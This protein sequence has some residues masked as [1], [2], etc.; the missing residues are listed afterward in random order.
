MTDREGESGLGVPIFFSLVLL[1]FVPIIA[2]VVDELV[3]R[4]NFFSRSSPEWVE[5]VVRMIY[6]PIIKMV[7]QLL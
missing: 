7:R 6:W 5:E 3:F 1:Y 4:T 2:I